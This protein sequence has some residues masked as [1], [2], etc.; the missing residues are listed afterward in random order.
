M[1]EWRQQPWEWADI[2]VPM[3]IVA[4]G[5]LSSFQFSGWPYLWLVWALLFLPCLTREHRSKGIVA[6]YQ[7]GIPLCA[8]T[9]SL[10]LYAFLHRRIRFA[11]YA[12][13]LSDDN[14]QITN[15][16]Q[17]M[18]TLYAICIA[19]TLWK[20]MNDHDDLKST[21]REEASKMKAVLAFLQYFQNVSDR[22]TLESINA[23]RNQLL[24]YVK[25][26]LMRKKK[27]EPEA[28]T[29]SADRLRECV[30][31]V[32]QL[33]TP[34]QNDKVALDGVIKGL[35]D[36]MMIR[37]RRIS[38]TE[39]RISPYLILI[40]S[41]IS[42]VSI[43]FFFIFDAQVFNAAHFIIPVL[44]FLYVFLLVLLIDLDQPF[45]GFWNVKA[46]VFEEVAAIIEKDSAATR[47]H[48]ETLPA[49]TLHAAA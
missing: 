6:T 42:L 9:L 49:E 26:V 29:A 31:L 15:F 23:I 5:L 27:Y 7:L 16:F 30:G 40:L 45:E 39:N 2:R 36:L 35:A 18:S 44:S 37:S 41:C 3:A 28:I 47:A 12:R 25:L 24:E 22:S 20:A 32:E 38:L 11:D 8:A 4:V 34:L 14:L 46:Q 33:R 10:L 1:T 21:L 48:M 43:S 13:Q 19:F 17:I